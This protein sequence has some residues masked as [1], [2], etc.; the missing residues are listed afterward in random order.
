MLYFK[1]VE[2]DLLL[3]RQQESRENLKII[4]I[5]GT[6]IDKLIVKLRIHETEQGS[7]NPFISLP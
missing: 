2:W 7:T 6:E 1:T 4:E 5:S 3:C